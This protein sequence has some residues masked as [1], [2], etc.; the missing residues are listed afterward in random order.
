VLTPPGASFL[1]TPRIRKLCEVPGAIL[2]LLHHPQQG[3]G[4]TLHETKSHYSIFD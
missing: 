1:R 2:E 4:P 3:T